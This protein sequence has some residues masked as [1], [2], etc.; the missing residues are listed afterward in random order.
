MN[1]ASHRH[2]EAVMGTVV[3][4]DLRGPVGSAAAARS[5]IGEVVAW[6]HW[7]DATF[8]T[9]KPGSE[10]NRLDRGELRPT[11]CHREVRSILALCDELHD[12]T[13]GYFDA[14]ADGRLDPSG[15]VKGWSI[16]RASA[17]LVDLGWPDHS[18]DGGGDVRLRGRHGE[19]RDWHV[20]ITHPFIAGA[21]CALVGLPQGA[22]ATS[23]TYERGFHVIDPHQRRPAIALAAVTVLGPEL[24]MTD[25]YATAA[26]AMG[27]GAPEW[28][29]GLHGHEA[30]VIDADGN[31]WS[32]PGFDRHR[33]DRPMAS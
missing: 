23:G 21:Y 28:L 13:N 24:T 29:E 33:L 6:L 5:A 30:L 18:I 16:E 11:A 31:G 12:V 17:M 32:T 4:F 10:I 27:T 7:V 9:Y 20:A 15:V 3:S 1:T 26:L 8:S 2:A 25:A 19:G 14:R 22:V